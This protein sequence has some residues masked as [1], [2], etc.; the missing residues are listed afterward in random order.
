M[1]TI[2]VSQGVD[3]REFTLVAFGGAGP[4]AAAFLAEE[5]DIR[6]VLIPRFPGTFSAWGM[7][8]TDLRHDFTMSFYR[9]A[10]GFDVDELES[11]YKELEAEGKES[12]LAEGIAEKDISYQ[13]SADMRYTGQEYTINVPV[14]NDIEIG[15]VIESFHDAHRR[16]YG[17]SSPGAPVEFVNVR[18]A[19]I[20]AVG[21]FSSTAAIDATNHDEVI[22]GERDAIFDGVAHMTPVVARERLGTDYTIDGPVII[23]EQS[24]TTIVPPGWQVN[25]DEHGNILLHREVG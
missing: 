14:P 4:M 16:R 3:P 6:E 17:H 25:V 5:L 1:R 21:K 20:G 7:L 22:L 8:Q 13:R 24:A 11:S 15:Q 12:V 18:V 23:E 2:T 19:A 10:E 9:A